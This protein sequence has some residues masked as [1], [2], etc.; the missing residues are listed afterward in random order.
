MRRVVNETLD[1]YAEKFGGFLE[2]WVNERMMVRN[3]TG[4]TF[5]LCNSSLVLK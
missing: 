2:D 1:M 5:E 3:S 4:V